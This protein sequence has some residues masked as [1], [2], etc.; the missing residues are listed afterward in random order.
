MIYPGDFRTT[1]DDA[2]T[3][4]HHET[5]PQ[6]LHPPCT[7]CDRPPQPFFPCS[8]TQNGVDTAGFAIQNP[9]MFGLQYIWGHLLAPNPIPKSQTTFSIPV[10]NATQF[11]CLDSLS[12]APKTRGLPQGTVNARS[13]HSVEVERETWRCIAVTLRAEVL[14]STSSSI[15]RYI[16][17]IEDALS[18]HAHPRD[19]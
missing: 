19:R 4:K 8:T 18:A 12:N 7:V 2:D 17:P 11:P 15:Q 6:H 13:N 9:L 14:R 10:Y 5:A 1:R 3:P 16:S